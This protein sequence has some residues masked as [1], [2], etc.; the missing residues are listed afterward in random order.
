L[1]HLPRVGW[2]LRIIRGDEREHK[3]YMKEVTIRCLVLR[4]LDVIVIALARPH[5]TCTSKLQGGRP[6]IKK[7]QLKPNSKA[8]R[9]HPG[10][11]CV[12]RGPIHLSFIKLMASTALDVLRLA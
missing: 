8:V 5:G 3:S 4:D 7:K 1:D 6:V 9:V 11:F 2:A 10:L 12:L